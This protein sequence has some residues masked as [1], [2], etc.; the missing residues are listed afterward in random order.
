MQYRK[1][2]EIGTPHASF[3]KSGD[4]GKKGYQKVADEAIVPGEIQHITGLDINR[5]SIATDGGGSV[6]DES[7]TT[8]SYS[9]SE[10]SDPDDP[11]DTECVVYP[12]RCTGVD[13]GQKSSIDLSRMAIQVILQNPRELQ[14]FNCVCCFVRF[15]A[16]EDLTCN[17]CDRSFDSTRLLAVH[18]QKKRHFGCSVCDSVFP[19][20]TRLETHKESLDHWSE[21]EGLTHDSE[22]DD[23]S[24]EEEG[25]GKVEELER[26]L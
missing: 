25:D 16:D 9:P 2:K 5:D 24:D 20:L 14:V 26:L 19:S 8:S 13:F 23:D 12:A 4:D 6:G 15:Y 3:D 22:S 11:S 21:D 7:D 17:V 1:F 10:C 18:Q